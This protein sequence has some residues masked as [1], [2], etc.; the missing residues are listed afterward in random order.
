[1]ACA[2]LTP[3][4]CAVALESIYAVVPL[5]VKTRQIAWAFASCTT[6]ES[7]A[8]PLTIALKSAVVPAIPSPLFDELSDQ[9][10]CVPWLAVWARNT[11]Q[12]VNGSARLPVQ[13]PPVS[14]V[15]MLNEPV[16]TVPV[17]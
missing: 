4:E 16:S 7:Y 15:P 1:M 2:A 3:S 11:E 8:L 17:A 10:P 6:V 13:V 5:A 9:I 14:V 12:T